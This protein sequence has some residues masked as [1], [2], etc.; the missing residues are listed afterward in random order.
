MPNGALAGGA[1]TVTH[2]PGVGPRG[3]AWG[4]AAAPA[5][6]PDP[7]ALDPEKAWLRPVSAAMPLRPRTLVPIRK[8]RIDHSPGRVESPRREKSPGRAIS[9]E[10]PVQPRPPSPERSDTPHRQNV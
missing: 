5:P 10:R 9:P 8:E 3:Y 6:G 7:L 1:L 4:V 2:A